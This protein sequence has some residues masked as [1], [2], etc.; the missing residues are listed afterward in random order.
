MF[1]VCGCSPHSGQG[2]RRSRDGQFFTQSVCQLRVHKPSPM[3]CVLLMGDTNA[4]V[5]SVLREVGA[6]TESKNGSRF[7]EVL[8]GNSM[9]AINTFVGDGGKRGIG[10]EL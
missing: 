5:G 3:K 6:E 7:R 1:S 8:N 2:G 9:C 4:V 10:M